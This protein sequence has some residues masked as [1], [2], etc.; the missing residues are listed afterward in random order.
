[1]DQEINAVEFS[2]A[3]AFSDPNRI[4]SRSSGG[5]SGAAEEFC[6]LSDF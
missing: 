2:G 4:G 1:V 6:G 3:V 5:L